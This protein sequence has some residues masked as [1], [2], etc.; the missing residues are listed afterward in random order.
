MPALTW[1]WIRHR[2]EVEAGGAVKRANVHA[3]GG[4]CTPSE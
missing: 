1:L 4:V 3:S 2:E